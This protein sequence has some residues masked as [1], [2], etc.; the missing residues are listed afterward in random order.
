MTTL[1][2]LIYLPH[3]YL[4]GDLNIF[5]F[6]ILIHILLGFFFELIFS[7]VQ[8]RDNILHFFLWFICKKAHNAF[9]FII[10]PVLLLLYLYRPLDIRI[11]QSLSICL[12]KLWNHLFL[13][14]NT[15]S[16][17][18]LSFSLNLNGQR[19]F[20]NLSN[21]FWFFE[22]H[23]WFLRDKEEAWKFV[24]LLINYIMSITEV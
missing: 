9:W 11:V 12:E 15:R 2:F 16:N 17:I 1:Y 18:I 14:C 5:I 7:L 20:I 10:H 4:F 19:I 13:H 22:K 3:I 6:W 8:L 21:F 23:R 24:K